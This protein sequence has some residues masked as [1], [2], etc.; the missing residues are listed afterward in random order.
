MSSNGIDVDYSTGTENQHERDKEHNYVINNISN[1]YV[2]IYSLEVED[3]VFKSPAFKNVTRGEYVLT[4]LQGK[5]KYNVC[6]VVR[7]TNK[8]V[9]DVNRCVGVKTGRYNNGIKTIIFSNIFYT[10]NVNP[11]AVEVIKNTNIKI[12]K[13][14]QNIF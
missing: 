11:R 13:A 6:V 10:K 9:G 5:M 1:V 3:L 2:T 14:Q 7:T 8:D 4:N 12:K